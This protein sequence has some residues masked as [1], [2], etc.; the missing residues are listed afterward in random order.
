MFFILLVLHGFGRIASGLV[1]L[2]ELAQVALGWGPGGS[3]IWGDKRTRSGVALQTT[4]ID[5]RAA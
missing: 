4:N 5:T 3:T 2:D 1:P